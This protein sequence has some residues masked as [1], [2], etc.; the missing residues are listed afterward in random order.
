MVEGGEWALTNST[1]N[2]QNEKCLF[3]QKCDKVG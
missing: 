2:A 3:L 1:Y